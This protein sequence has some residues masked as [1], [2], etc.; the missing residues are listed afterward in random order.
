MLVHRTSD[1]KTDKEM[2]Q[3]NSF[4]IRGLDGGIGRPACRQAGAHDSK[5]CGIN[6]MRVRFSL[7]A[8][9]ETLK[10]L[11][12]YYNFIILVKF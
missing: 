5:S 11:L 12:F 8:P 4:Q 2:Y 3:K 1:G 9:R 10:W 6:P 7:E